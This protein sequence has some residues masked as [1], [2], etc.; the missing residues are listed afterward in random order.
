MKDERFVYN[1]NQKGKEI[2]KP[3]IAQ[4]RTRR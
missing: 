4:V 2:V 1:T 3:C